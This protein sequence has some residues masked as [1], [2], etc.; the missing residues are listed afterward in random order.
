MVGAHRPTASQADHASTLAIR[1][2][3]QRSTVLPSGKRFGSRTGAPACSGRAA[4]AIAP[5]G[6]PPAVQAVMRAGQRPHR[7]KRE[8]QMA[9]A[10]DA[11]ADTNLLPAGIM[12]LL[13]PPAVSHDRI[14]VA[15]RT[16]P[17][18]PFLP[19]LAFFRRTWHKDNQ[20][21][22]RRPT[23]FRCLGW[24]TVIRLPLLPNATERE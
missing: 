11:A 20:G 7:K 23:G 14:P 16:A 17:L 24:E 5:A 1:R 18:Q 4:F 21:A 15:T 22:G 13:H 6:I 2:R 12:G 19:G 3:I 9:G 10:A 8:A